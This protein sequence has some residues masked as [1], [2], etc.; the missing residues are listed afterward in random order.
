MFNYFT[1][2]NQLQLVRQQ[3]T[4]YFHEDNTQSAFSSRNR[5]IR[6]SPHHSHFNLSAVMTFS[7]GGKARV[8]TERTRSQIQVAGMGV[9]HWE[10]AVSPWRWVRS[11][12]IWKTLRIGALLLSME[13][14]QLV[15]FSP[16]VRMSPGQV[17][18]ASRSPQEKAQDEVERNKI[19]PIYWS[20][21]QSKNSPKKT[22]SFPT[23]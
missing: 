14:G 8:I 4:F 15:W 18:L 9:L 17:F 19:K 11:S 21:Y 22:F 13:T 7:T 3:R 12:V 20:Q 6:A 1:T 23:E 16:L 2:F 10:A 5:I